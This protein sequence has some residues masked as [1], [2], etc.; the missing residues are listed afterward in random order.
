[1]TV[2]AHCNLCGAEF[3]PPQAGERVFDSELGRH[4]VNEH[5]EAIQMAM[6]VGNLLDHY[7]E[8]D[9]GS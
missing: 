8:T 7:G 2:R 4:F 6:S 1:M 3:P 5:Y 9:E